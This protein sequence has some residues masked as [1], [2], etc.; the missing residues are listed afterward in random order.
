MWGVDGALPGIVMW[1]EPEVDGQRYYQEYYPGEAEDV[2]EV[3]LIGLTMKV[4]AGSFE[5]CIETH[6]TS[7]LERSADEHKYYCPGVGNV[8]SEEPDVDEELFSY[9]GL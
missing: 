7:T 4:E 9:A 5:D 1:A 6:D 2:G 3:I 8:L